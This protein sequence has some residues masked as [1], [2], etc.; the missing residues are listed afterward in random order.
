[1]NKHSKPQTR[2]RLPALLIAGLV[3][4]FS[5]TASVAGEAGAAQTAKPERV[6]TRAQFKAPNPFHNRHVMGEKAEFA[7]VEA[8][9]DDSDRAPRRMFGKMGNQFRK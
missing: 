5:V 7:R 6:A 4:G 9:T 1:M 3:A 2:V 8:A